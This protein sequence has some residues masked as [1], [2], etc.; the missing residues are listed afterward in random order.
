MTGVDGQY[1]PRGPREAPPPAPASLA[2]TTSHSHRLPR[3]RRACSLVLGLQP[4]SATS[5]VSS[6]LSRLRPS[7]GQRPP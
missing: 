1:Y 6:S 3:S 7:P 2:P 5:T 4:R